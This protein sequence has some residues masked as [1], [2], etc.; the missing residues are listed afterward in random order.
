[1]AV[2]QEEIYP[3]ALFTRDMLE[4]KSH[5]WKKRRKAACHQ[6]KGDDLSQETKWENW[7][8]SKHYE[9]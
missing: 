3:R 9:K 2:I 8:G 1:L 6:H 7:G 4:S 5:G